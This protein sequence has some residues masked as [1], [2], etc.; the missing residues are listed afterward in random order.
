[1]E[2]QR[3]YDD[4]CGDYGGTNSDGDPCGR[5]AGWG[6]DADSGLCR[7]HHEDGDEPGGRPS[8]LDDVRDDLLTAAERGT[9]KEGCA[10]AA[11]IA[12]STLYK[13]LDEIP[14]FSEAFTRARAKAEQE[15]IEAAAESDPKWVLER[16]YGYVKTEKREVDLEADVDGTHDVTAE[17]V[18]YGSEDT[19]E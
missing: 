1:M 2:E 8:K 7:S 4:E 5:P 16:S 3:R 13:W 17:F 10:R 6:R 15:L 11:G 14:E 9:T 18:T 19:D 12:P